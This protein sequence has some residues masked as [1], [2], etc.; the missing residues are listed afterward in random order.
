MDGFG[1]EQKEGALTVRERPNPSPLP[2]LY[3]RFFTSYP[4]SAGCDT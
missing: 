1:A 2:L 4:F 3:D